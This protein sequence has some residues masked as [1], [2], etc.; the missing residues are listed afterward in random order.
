[1]SEAVSRR[2]LLAALALLACSHAGRARA[3]EYAS[4][5]DALEAIEGFEVVVDRYLLRLHR[6]VPA[7]RAMIESFRRDRE[8]HRSHRERVRRRLGLGYAAIA[9]ASGEAPAAPLDVVREAQSALVYAHAE[10]LPTLDDSVSVG[11][12]M[13][14]MADLARQL[15]LIDLWIEAEA[16]RG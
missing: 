3:A 1:M 13:S 4:A 2:Q 5:K 9:A 16:A 6:M 7:S 11:L 8:R 14:D 15:T 12:L 10:T